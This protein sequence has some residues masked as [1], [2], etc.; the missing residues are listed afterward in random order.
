MVDAAAGALPA[1]PPEVLRELYV[2]GAEHRVI[3][4]RDRHVLQVRC[5]CPVSLLQGITACSEFVHKRLSQDGMMAADAD[6]LLAG[7]GAWLSAAP[8]SRL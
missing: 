5:V 3:D 4:L 2:I 7:C 1:L 6:S 8:G